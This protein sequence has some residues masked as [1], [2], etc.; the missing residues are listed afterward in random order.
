M[1]TRSGQDSDGPGIIALIAAC[2]APYPGC[3]MDVHGEC[4]DLLEHASD[5]FLQGA[6][7][8]FVDTRDPLDRGDVSAKHLF[9]R[10]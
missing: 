9:Q 10:Q 1:C 3:V 2:W 7:L 8:P 4:P 6:G 5:R